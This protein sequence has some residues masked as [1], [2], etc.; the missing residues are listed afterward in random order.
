MANVIYSHKV[1]K[2]ITWPALIGPQIPPVQSLLLTSSVD[3]LC[4]KP[5]LESLGSSPPR[6]TTR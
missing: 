5:A 1:Y 4:E 2:S 3:W 6:I